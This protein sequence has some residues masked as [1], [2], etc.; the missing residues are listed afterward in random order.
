MGFHLIQIFCFCRVCAA[1]ITDN[2]KHSYGAL[3]SSPRHSDARYISGCSPA[4]IAFLID[5][6][7]KSRL[8]LLTCRMPADGTTVVNFVKVTLTFWSSA[9]LDWVR[10]MLTLTV[11]GRV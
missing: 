10:H 5:A 2:N 3:S 7:Y 9:T 1:C 11:Q 8:P 4:T 6:L